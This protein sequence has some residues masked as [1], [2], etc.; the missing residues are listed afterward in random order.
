M[1]VKRESQNNAV[2]Y[3]EVSVIMEPSLADLEEFYKRAQ[4]A[5][6]L[7]YDI[8]T[9]PSRHQILCIGFG[10]G[11]LSMVVPFVDRRKPDYCYWSSIHDEVTA[12]N[13]VRATLSLPTP[14]ITQNGLYDITWLWKIMGIRPAG[15]SEDTMLYHHS[16][17]PEM[18]KGL[19]FL[20]SIYC[21]LPAW[22]TMHSRGDFNKRE[23]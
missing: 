7:S 14:K 6:C 21:N 10:L 9:K 8:E 2:K 13:F 23:D 15:V 22:K 19:D 3:D 11:E 4:N 1:K 5:P 17:F 16:L 12:W 18:T 20:G